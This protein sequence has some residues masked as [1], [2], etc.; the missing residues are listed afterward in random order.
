MEDYRY[1]IVRRLVPKWFFEIVVHICAVVVAQPLLLLTLCFPIRAML[2]PPSELS[3]GPFP[4]AYISLAAFSPLLSTARKLGIP[5]D[6]PV[7]HVGDALAALL[8]LTAVYIQK[9]TD[10]AMYA[11]QE[12]KHGAMRANPSPRVIEDGEPLPAQVPPEFYP[13]FPTKGIHAV[14]RH[15]N[16]TSEQTFWLA[17]GLLGLGAGPA[18]PRVGSCLLPPFLLS[19]LFLGSTTL[20]EWITSHRYPAYGA[21][22]QLVGQFTPMETGIKWIWTTM[23]GTRA[24]LQA[25]LDPLVRQD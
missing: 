25:E 11:Y 23:R 17:Q 5:L 24:E 13:G 12:A 2:L 18:A 10:D 21:Y 3:Y 7:L 8:A 1:P 4:S 14:V 20:T 19:L 22:K 6:T 16:F 15:A 9:K